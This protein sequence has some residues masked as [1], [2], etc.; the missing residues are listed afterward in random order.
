[1][2]CTLLCLLFHDF[3]GGGRTGKGYWVV[4]FWVS[5]DGILEL[6]HV[7]SCSGNEEWIVEL[8]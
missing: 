2:F 5:G 3:T 4:H 8:C 7:E 1:M 6:I